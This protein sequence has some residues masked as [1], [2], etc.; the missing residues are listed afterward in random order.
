[1]VKFD[2][3][4]FNHKRKL[5]RQLLNKF[6]NNYYELIG[7]L[8]NLFI[9][10]LILFII[11]FHWIHF[12]WRISYHWV[13]KSKFLVTHLSAYTNKHSTKKRVKNKKL[14]FSWSEIMNTV[15]ETNCLI[16]SVTLLTL[17]N[18]YYFLY[19]CISIC[20]PY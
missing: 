11:L 2:S 19:Y 16:R 18:R 1:M 6:Y 8:L 7:F 17:C 9:L 20:D 10:L 3:I 12:Y 5:W 13:L 15:S 4:K 14:A